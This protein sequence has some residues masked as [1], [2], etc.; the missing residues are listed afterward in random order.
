MAMSQPRIQQTI[1]NVKTAERQ[2]FG[3][4]QRS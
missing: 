4:P 3:D 2:D 1:I